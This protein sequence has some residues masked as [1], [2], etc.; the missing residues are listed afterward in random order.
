MYTAVEKL[1]ELI[2]ETH[3]R[4]VKY[5]CDPARDIVQDNDVQRML[6]EWKDEY[7]VWMRL[8][9]LQDAEGMSN[10]QWHQCLRKAFRAHVFNFWKLRNDTLLPDRASQQRDLEDRSAWHR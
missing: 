1:E 3:A 4:R 5:C 6:N 9:A 8:E 2:E 7:R 10:Q